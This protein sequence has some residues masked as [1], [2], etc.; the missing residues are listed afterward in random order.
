MLKSIKLN[1]N[2]F[3]YGVISINLILFFSFITY[4]LFLYNLLPNNLVILVYPFFLLS[5]NTFVVIITLVIESLLIGLY[6]TKSRKQKIEHI[7]E[8]SI[9]F[10]IEDSFREPT[11]NEIFD[12][13]IE[14]ELMSGTNHNE[15]THSLE[16][17]SIIDFHT[18]SNEIDQGV[19]N[20]EIVIQGKD[21]YDL[22]PQFLDIKDN[23]V[24][25]EVSI[26]NEIETEQVLQK[27]NK[28]PQKFDNI[29]NDFQFA[30]YKNIVESNW[31]YEK[32]SDRNRVGFEKYAI[33]ESKISLADLEVLQNSKA[34]YR[35]QIQHPTG[36][37]YV[38]SATKNGENRIIFETI[39]RIARK[40][41]L[42]F[43]KRK[44]I[45]PNWKEYDLAKQTWEFDFEL[46][47]INLIGCIWSMDCFLTTDNK[48][49]EKKLIT[50]RKNEL[51][52]LIAAVTLK[53]K[54]EGIA[55]IVTTL[56]ED[57]NLLKKIVKS[58][59]WGDVKVLCFSNHNFFND[60]DKLLKH[61][62]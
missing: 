49:G 11:D 4:I 34:I 6:Y 41:R 31:L 20:S 24:Q 35:E 22:T 45:F 33:D 1:K 60:L 15:E 10:K 59:G 29:L 40:K 42:K 23:L 37:F 9:E 51:K 17:P 14:Q 19:E 48:S 44:I 30:F 27:I 52:A 38:Y 39:R 56:K 21:D 43:V 54:E 13:K 36:E 3:L 8:E 55:L 5:N 62:G 32:A 18:I 28:E 16:I 47:Q 46:P 50:E 7:K 25:E 57:A 12:Q 53:L 58:T 61:H 2:Y 26:N